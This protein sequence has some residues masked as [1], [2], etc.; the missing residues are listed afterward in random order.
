MNN[1]RLLVIGLSVLVLAAGAVTATGTFAWYTST[2]AGITTNVTGASASVTTPPQQYAITKVTVM[3]DTSTGI[4]PAYT[5]QSSSDNVGNYEMSLTDNRPL[6]DV[7]GDAAGNSPVTLFKPVF[8]SNYT[9]ANVGDGYATIFDVSDQTTAFSAL[10][11]GN[12]YPYVRFGFRLQNIT[13]GSKGVF[14]SYQLTESA[15]NVARV[16]VCTIAVAEGDKNNAS[17][18]SYAHSTWT[19]RAYLDTEG[20]TINPVSSATAGSGEGSAGYSFS[21]D[22]VGSVY[23]VGNPYSTYLGSSKAATNAS[24][25]TALPV[26]PIVTLNAKNTAGDCAFFVVTIWVE[27][28]DPDAWTVGDVSDDIVFTMSIY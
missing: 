10:S 25:A 16:S 6:T 28:Q 5:A 15:R 13:T 8:A 17:I 1:Q 26:S 9:S 12:A 14:P 3:G 2:R 24:S 11:T 18:A 19:E 20:E 4:S 27:G 21:A 23:V 22:G 7:S